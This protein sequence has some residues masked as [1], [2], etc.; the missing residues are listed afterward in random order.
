MFKRTLLKKIQHSIDDAT[1][2]IE[3]KIDTFVREV[4]SLM[5]KHE[6]LLKAINED[7]LV[8]TKILEHLENLEKNE[9][10]T[11]GMGSV[12]RKKR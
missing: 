6:V 7:R 4:N 8:I 1:C 5:N 3:N 12:K 9:N 10:L 2:T 11:G